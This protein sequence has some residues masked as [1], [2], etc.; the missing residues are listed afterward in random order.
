MQETAVAS[1]L[2]MKGVCKRFGGVVALDGVDLEVA[3]GEVHA[4]VGENGA[5]KSTLMKVLS[6]VERADDGDMRFEGDRWSPG[7]PVDA[8]AAG[9]AMVHQELALASHLTIAE[10]V[11]L[12]GESTRG[13][14]G[15]F[16]PMRRA[17]AHRRAREALDRLGRGDLDPGRKVSTLTPAVR[18]LVEIARAIAFDARVIV[19][20]EPTSSLG[21]RDAER[22]LDVVRRLRDEGI[23]VIYISHHLEEILAVAD[24]Y[25][26]LRDGRTV[27]SGAMDGVDESDLVERMIGR[28]LDAVF[29]PRREAFGDP[30][31]VVEHLYGVDLPR[32]ASI[33]VRRGEILGLAGLV[34]SG[35]SEFLRAIA[36]LDPIRAG[37]IEVLGTPVTRT[38]TP[39]RMLDRGVGFLSEDRKG[40]GLALRMSVGENLLLPDLGSVSRRGCL[41]T[42]LAR[43]TT[44]RW[45]ET[46]S[47]RSGTF[48]RRIGTL[49]GG[50]QQKVAIARLLHLDA[51][52]LLLDEPT[53]G[54][55][56]G[57]KVQVYHLLDRL[58]RDGKAILVAS[59]HLPEL[60]GLCDRI[61]VMHRGSLG[62]TRP[63]AESTEAELMGEAVM[64][65]DPSTEN[66]A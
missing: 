16:G 19:M 12:G 61:A 18:Q 45:A 11:V 3:P 30:A 57:S 13:R 62:R 6:G 47:I 55:D 4:L 49:S 50:N 29:P 36:G 15:R 42:G 51:D 52:V 43:R 28:S 21:R 59:G 27:A 14:L 37:R 25:T 63:G 56:I 32:G 10:N 34:G 26:V 22:L 1:R 5:G 58:A 8:R 20:D 53:R 48:D 46:L 17:E 24:R 44:R 39:R 35:R 23:S 66:A 33:E 38:M 2:S 41:S 7:G 54:I 40:E 31:L 65:T 9:V 60:M 64:G